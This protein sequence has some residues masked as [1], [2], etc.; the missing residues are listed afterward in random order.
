M[1][2]FPFDVQQKKKKEN[3]FIFRSGRERWGPSPS[4]ALVSNCV[5]FTQ[6]C[7]RPLDFTSMAYFTIDFC[8]LFLG[9]KN[10]PKIA[11]NNLY[12]SVLS[13]SPHTTINR[14]ATKHD[15]TTN[16]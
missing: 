16:V 12:F 1:L 5:R 15:K 13:L 9:G 8:F 10:P 11:E 4:L 14:T 7:S 3:N 6:F 2:L